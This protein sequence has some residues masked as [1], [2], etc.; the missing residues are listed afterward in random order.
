MICNVAS[1]QILLRGLVGLSRLTGDVRY[2]RRALRLMSYFM[3]TYQSAETGLLPWGG[4]MF[5]DLADGV[6]VSTL[7]SGARVHELKFHFPFYDLMWRA[8]AGRTRRFVEGF[9]QAHIWNWRT[10]VFNR[11]GDLDHGRSRQK[12]ASG[13]AFLNTGTDLMAAAGIACVKCGSGPY[14]TRAKRLL[15]RYEGV[16]DPRTGLMPYQFNLRPSGPEEVQLGHLGITSLTLVPYVHAVAQN[17]VGLMRLSQTLGP[18]QGAFF[19]ESARAS[20]RAFGRYGYSASDRS[21]RGMLRTDTGERIKS[22]AVNRNHD[23]PYRRDYWQRW[24]FSR[25]QCLGQLLFA[26]ALGFRLTGDGDLWLT[27]N[28]LLSLLGLKRRSDWPGPG[29]PGERTLTT[30]DMGYVLQGLLEL[31]EAVERR[32]HLDMAEHVAQW[33]VRRFTEDGWILP[34]KRSGKVKFNQRLLLALLRLESARLGRTGIVP[35]EWAGKEGNLDWKPRG[36]SRQFKPLWA[37][38]RRRH[39][40]YM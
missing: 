21:Y 3:N 31:H 11:H 14:L 22:T 36:R 9:W 35:D 12:G 40:I 28:R 30:L 7:R 32:E 18:E 17:A 2:E 19:L 15:G 39:L 20:L 10:L 13:L 8:D 4:H 24:K 5:V 26:Y 38:P 37:L 16:R 27:I 23:G 1:Q 25:N 33:T 29:V 34:W 6:P